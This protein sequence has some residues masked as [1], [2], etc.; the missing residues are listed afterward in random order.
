MRADIKTIVHSCVTLA[1][2]SRGSI[3]YN[4]MLNLTPF[5]REIVNDFQEKHI[6]NELKKQ[7]PDIEKSM[8]VEEIATIIQMDKA[9]K[10]H[11]TN[12]YKAVLDSAYGA[13]KQEIDNNNNVTLTNFSIKDVLD[14]D[15]S[16]PE[17]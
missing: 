9:I 13:P 11:D 1:Y 8:T 17:V 3:P 2:F 12:A 5:E 6:K 16:K 4:D 14:F 7:Y 10:T 15:N